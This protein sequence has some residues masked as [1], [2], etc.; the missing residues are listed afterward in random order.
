M[1]QY[2]GKLS[3]KDATTARMLKIAP[4]I[5][6]LAASLPGTFSDYHYHRIGGCLFIAG[7]PLVDPWVRAGAGDCYHTPDLPQEMAV[8]ITRPVSI[9]WNHGE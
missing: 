1:S 9:G 8:K 6:M 7:R 5:A 3:G 4:W 2:E